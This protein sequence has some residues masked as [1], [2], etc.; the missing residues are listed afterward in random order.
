MTTLELDALYILVHFLTQEVAES[1]RHVA[2]YGYHP[3][4]DLASRVDNLH[5]TR[6]NLPDDHGKEYYE[7][8]LDTFISL[9]NEYKQLK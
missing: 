7:R 4:Q 9:R 1:L 3:L 8:L 6:L 5:E 2:P